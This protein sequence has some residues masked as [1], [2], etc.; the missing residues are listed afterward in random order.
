MNLYALRG[1][2]SRSIRS[3]SPK[4]V[5]EI[6]VTSRTRVKHSP[7]WSN[8]FMF[9]TSI[10]WFACLCIRTYHVH[11]SYIVHCSH[12]TLLWL[13]WRLLWILVELLWVVKQGYDFKVLRYRGNV[14]M[15]VWQTVEMPEANGYLVMPTEQLTD[16]E[17]LPG[18]HLKG[19]KCLKARL[20]LD[21]K[22]WTC[23]VFVWDCK[24][25]D[26]FLYY[27][28]LLCLKNQQI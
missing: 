26:I 17:W 23:F 18:E 20:V 4:P 5:F 9:T 25:A 6:I 13:T 27:A 16:W 12:A 8:C 24:F 3:G 10:C 19:S 1:H 22:Y 2:L 28:A 21:M 7:G 11:T 15:T 14:D